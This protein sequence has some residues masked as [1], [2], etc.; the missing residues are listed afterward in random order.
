MSESPIQAFLRAVDALDLEAVVPLFG[1]QAQL[2]MPFAEE[3]Q[4]EAG[5]RA[6]FD[7]FLSGLRATEHDL[8]SEWNPN[9][10]TWIAEFSATYE[11]T[12]F[13][14]RG[15][16]KRAIFVRTADGVIQEMSL[17]GANE[18]PLAEDGRTYTDIRG[19]HGWLPT[20]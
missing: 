16:Y 14:R 18:L 13:S 1:P 7:K 10:D 12:D 4:G 19:P 8:T 20:L 2:T 3:A 11:L 5:L 6:E 9:P 15:P 17:Y